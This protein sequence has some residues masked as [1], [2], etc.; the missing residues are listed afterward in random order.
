[1]FKNVSSQTCGI[2]PPPCPP[3]GSSR[4]TI[5]SQVQCPPTARR[6]IVAAATTA[7]TE[8]MLKQRV[9]WIQRCQGLTT[10]AATRW[11]KV[12]WRP[13][14]QGGWNRDERSRGNDSRYNDRRYNSGNSGVRG[15]RN[16]GRDNNGSFF[17]SGNRA[18]GDRRRYDDHDR[19]REVNSRN[20]S[21]YNSN[22]RGRAPTGSDIDRGHSGG[23]QPALKRSRTAPSQAQE[24]YA[25]A[26]SSLQKSYSE[27]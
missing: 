26:T 19:H 5:S 17:R 14:G 9:P 6:A 12:W 24:P 15:P 22:K 2:P 21:N 8:S 18:V 25:A 7:A 27:L 23:G 13:P 1:M 10:Q 20:D 3:R 11:R 4:K 16:N